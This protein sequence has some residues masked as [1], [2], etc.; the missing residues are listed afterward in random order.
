MKKSLIIFVYCFI[1]FTLSRATSL[2]EMYDNAESKNGYGKFITLEKDSIYTG[3]FTQNISS[4]CIQGNSGIIDF[5]GSPI[6]VPEEDYILDIDH[7]IMKTSSDTQDVFL[8]YKNNSNGK[9]IHNTFWDKSNN[10]S[11]YAIRLEKCTNDSI[12]IKNNIFCN[13]YS[14]LYFDI[15]ISGEINNNDNIQLEIEHNLNW[16][17]KKT[18]LYYAGWTMPA[19]PFIPNPGN[20]EIIGNPDFVNPLENNF[21]LQESSIGIDNGIETT[22]EY[23]GNDPDLGA[24]ESSFSKFRGTKI[25]GDLTQ[26]LLKSNSPYIIND[27]LNIKLNQQI[28]IE[29]GV[30][31]RI[32]CMKS[33]SVDGQV[34]FAGTI[35]DSIYISNNSC[36]NTQWQSIRFNEN[37]SNLSKI[38]YAKIRYGK[39]TCLND[40]LSIENC[41][42]FNT[43]KCEKNCK[44]KIANNVF[45][46][47]ILCESNS[48]PLIENNIF[49]SSSIHS[50]SANPKIIRNKFMGQTYRMPQSYWMVS[51]TDKS[52]AYIESNLF[53]NNYGAILVTDSSSFVS[54]NNLIY[55]CDHATTVHS[56]SSGIIL[57]NTIYSNGRREFAGSDG[58]GINCSI[59]SKINVVNSIVWNIG[60]WSRA[61]GI[62]D[63]S[64][65]NTQNCVLSTPFEG[66]NIIY[67]D[68]SFINPGEN[69]FRISDTSVCIDSGISDTLN[70]YM[71][72]LDYAGNPRMCGKNIDIGCFENQNPNNIESIETSVSTN[73][74]LYQNY[75]NPFNATTRIQYTVPAKSNVE[76]L[77]YDI[78]GNQVDVL[79]SGIQ[80]SGQYEVIWDAQHMTSGI[81]F[82]EMAAGKFR[83]IKK[84]LIVK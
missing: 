8:L 24:C 28:F 78:C 64:I 36:Y 81:Y 51:I 77:V 83:S 38:N 43:L 79:H 73:Y 46:S 23:Q 76:I 84:C 22:I 30:E 29:S 17:C 27:D 62:F 39:I 12:E 11:I 34:E 44:I 35:D 45:H 50:F 37:A 55:T 15:D 49:Y 19:Q 16:Q 75:P 6:I 18:Y 67:D 41:N 20:G 57:N 31:I 42:F 53:K 68:P 7:C 56:N 5:I 65:V 69:N 40:S 58:Y 47:P 14:P 13:L 33:I 2:Q 74:E 32:N 72:Q 63:S 52:N 70:E 4:V 26:N 60:E 82:I 71:S 61:I 9:I 21:T 59:N 66:K 10:N 3:S 48:A 54:V 25:S 1:M 80:Y